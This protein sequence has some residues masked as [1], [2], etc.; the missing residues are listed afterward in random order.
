MCVL[1]GNIRQL[2]WYWGMF[3]T[4][5]QVDVLLQQRVAGPDDGMKIATNSTKTV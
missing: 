5:A 2:R 1:C 4:T 3:E